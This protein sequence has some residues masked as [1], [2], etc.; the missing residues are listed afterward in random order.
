MKCP[1]GLEHIRYTP[2][3]SSGIFSLKR[4]LVRVLQDGFVMQT[5]DYARTKKSPSTP[6]EMLRQMLS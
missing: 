3:T 2:R 5:A 1:Y 4:K 6:N